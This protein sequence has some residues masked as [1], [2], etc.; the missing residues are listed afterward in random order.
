M[1]LVAY[2]GPL[3]AYIVVRNQ[4]MELHERVLTPSHIRHLLSEGLGKMGIKIASEAKAE[5]EK[6][7]PVTMIAQ[8]GKDPQQNQANLIEARQS[9]GFLPAKELVAGAIDNRA[10][11]VMLD[12][13]PQEVTTRYMVDGVWH[14]AE[15]HERDEGDNLLSV[16]KRLAA[17]KPEDRRSRQQGRLGVEYQGKQLQCTLVSQGTKTGERV[18]LTM[19]DTRNPFQSLEQLGMR[20]KMVERLK[21]LMLTK[22]GFLLFSAMPSGGLS[23]TLEIALRSTDRL[24]RDFIAV[25]DVGNP[26][27]DVENVDPVRF[28]PAA[29]E[30]PDQL[31]DTILRKQPDVLVFPELVNAATVKRLCQAAADEQLIFGCIRAK[32]AVESLVRV[33]LMKVPAK[34]LAPVALAVVNQRL[35]RKLCE[36]CQEE[37]VPP[38]ALLTKLGIPAGR[39]DK[40]YRHPENPEKEC[41][42]CHGLGYIGRTSI[43]EL[44]VI[45]DTLRNTLLREPKLEVLRSGRSQSG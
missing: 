17:L 15:N 41:P 40:L 4:Q 19:S 26:M 37:Y 18:L 28:N 8:G 24:L 20:P 21:E 31:L 13:S 23:T 6:G 30:T 10:E 29:G 44:L 22:R 1:C 11:K 2:L 12:F 25:E 3:I 34:S 27:H 45:D 36:A 39:V 35:V 43:F 32:E 33:L 38:P 14:D 9:K 16:L 5:W 42:E 7:V